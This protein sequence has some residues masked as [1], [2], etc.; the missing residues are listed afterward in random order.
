MAYGLPALY[1][2][3]FHW[4][5]VTGEDEAPAGPDGQYF[6]DFYGLARAFENYD[7]QFIDAHGLEKGNLYKL[8]NQTKNGIEQQRYQ[9]PNAVDDGSDHNNIESRLRSSQ[10]DA[11]VEAHVNWDKWYRY[12][13]VAQAIRH[14]DY[15]PDANKNAAWYF[16]PSYTEANGFLGKL[17]TLPFD[18]DA[19]WGPNWNAGQDRQY[20][21]IFASGGKLEFQKDYRSCIR[22]VRDLLWQPDEL[23]K[24]IRQ[25][26]A[27]IKPLEQPD[28]D[29]WRSAPAAAGRQYFGA[30]NQRDLEGKAADMMRFA[31]TGGSWPGGTVGAGGRA[32]F[33]DSFSASRDGRNL[34]ETPAIEYIGDARFAMDDIRFRS[35]AFA[36]PQGDDSFGAMAW[37]I[38]EITPIDNPGRVALTDPAWRIEPVKLEFETLWTSGPI[39]FTPE[40]RIPEEVLRPGRFYRVRVRMQDDTRLWSH[41]SDP[42]EFQTAAP[43]AP[44]AEQGALRVSEIMYNPENDDEYEYIELQNIGG[45]PI[46][47]EK[48]RFDD[49]IEFAFADSDVKEL[50]AGAYVVVVKDR[51]VFAT[52]YDTAEILIAGEYRGQLSNGGETVRII[53][54]ASRLI[55]EFTYDDLWF[56]PTDGDGFSLVA[57]NVEDELS[58]WSEA[59]GWRSSNERGGSPGQDDASEVGGLQIL[60]DINQDNTLN[61]TDGIGLL[62]FLFSA[63]GRPLPCG[64]GTLSD[65]A[66]VSLLDLNADQAVNLSDGISLL[67]YLFANGPGPAGGTGCRAVPGCSTTCQ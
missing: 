57:A 60:G 46:D 61:I 33:L 17:W 2:H 22:E 64:D 51:D 66:N 19:T 23:H 16:E 7:A 42:I 28:I 26:A 25:T 48:I 31:F 30:A 38:A 65:P 67:Q 40:M 41:W 49:G 27:M 21:T 29:R 45:A 36:D 52:R 11:W 43:L 55:Q 58:K 39:P 37:R 4:R 24:V 3:S 20:E 13:A 14:Y 44:S 54:G 15:W 1:G 32:A 12:H 56:P 47:L 5:V 63:A 35:S 53:Q 8:V 34:P 6:G 50:P 18:T 10:P 59:E 9:A 62:Q